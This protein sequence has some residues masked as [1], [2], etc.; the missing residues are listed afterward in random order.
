MVGVAGLLRLARWWRRRDAESSGG[1]GGGGG[2]LLGGDDATGVER[3]ARGDRGDSS[4]V[5]VVGAA[6]SE[7]TSAARDGARG[8]GAADA[9]GEQR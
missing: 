9:G 3:A 5:A 1:S 6:T 8:V 4:N 7:P 2:V